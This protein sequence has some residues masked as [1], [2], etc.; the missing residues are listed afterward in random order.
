MT[1]S[2]K[3]L[4]KLRVSKEGAINVRQGRVSDWNENWTLYR[5]KV[6]LNRLTQRQSVTVPLIKAT[7]KTL[8]KD[9]DEPP[10]LYFSNIDNDDQA[11]VFYNE[12]YK[13]SAI[14]NQLIIKDIVDKRQV[15]LFGR[16]FKALNILNGRF[17]WEVVGPEDMLVDRYV[18]PSNLDSARFVIRQHI[19]LPLSSLATNPMFDNAA[20]RRLQMY[21]MTEMGLIKAE[22]NQQDWIEK[23]KRM[24]AMGVIDAYSPK[25][26]EA[27]VELNYFFIKEFN[28]K[29]KE[30]DIT[31][32]VT[33]QDMEVLYVNKL[34][35]F[36]GQTSDHYWRY[37]YPFTTWA[38]ETERTDFWSDGVVDSL[39]PLNK[40]LNAWFS[41]KVENRTLRNFGMNYFNSSLGTE[42]FDPQTFTPEPWG[43]FPVPVPEGGKIGDQIMRVEI[44]DLKDTTEEMNFIMA[45]AERVSAATSTQ[46]GIE[47]QRQVTLGEVKLA[48][49]NAQERVKSM[50][51]YYTASWE[52]FG[53]KYVK[54]L[55]AA[56]DMIEPVVISRK[57]RLTK[58]NYSKTI[59]PAMWLTK[60]GYKCEI[61]MKEDHQ[62]QVEESLQKLQ[63]AKALMPA[64][65][66]LDGIIKKKSLEFADLSSTE[67]A[68]VLKLDEL[69]T[70]QMMAA[71]Q[72]QAQMGMGVGQ[73]GTS[74]APSQQGGQQ[75]GQAM[76]PQPAVATPM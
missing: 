66:V 18:D 63:F 16:S 42:G 72:A 68:E 58:K 19:Y 50:A 47:Q 75:V 44:P 55:E 32:V 40:V 24:A 59:S 7:V 27:Y 69:Q 23:N 67:M 22:E 33:A 1:A 8:L 56:S 51:V 30:D 46:Q 65:Q 38:D 64:N 39:R 11:E 73:P 57:G 14:D 48:L 54:M 28:E 53:Q 13:E 43:W 76:L 31:F 70:Q 61:Q 26:G 29:T 17:S 21:F 20:V 34:E 5:D 71:A 41:Q 36:I 35:D 2:E 49:N 25:L 52:D 6:Q 15:M 4:E 37:H 60:N 45:L 12:Y 10:I 9:V 62:K 3:L 74:A